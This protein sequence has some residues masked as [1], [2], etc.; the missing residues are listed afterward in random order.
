MTYIPRRNDV[1][2]CLKLPPANIDIINNNDNYK[3]FK[4]I[5]N[6]D[7]DLTSS[8][9][10]TVLGTTELSK[11]CNVECLGLLFKGKQGNGK[12][13]CSHGNKEPTFLRVLKHVSPPSSQILSRKLIKE[14]ELT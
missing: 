8:M 14:T 11:Q 6:I 10:S 9:P 3:M 13:K 7:S 1:E 5:Q 4:G 2:R 12:C